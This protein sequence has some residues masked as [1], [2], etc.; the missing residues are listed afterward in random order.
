MPI[1]THTNLPAGR[2]I[3]V[4]VVDDSVV[5]RR[6]ITRALS[7]ENDLEV[8]GAASNGELALAKIPQLNPDV[9]TLDI[10][11]PKM[12]G[13]EAL[14]R[15]RQE[16]PTLTVIMFSALTE[17]GAA[18]TLEA[19]TLGASDYVTKSGSGGSVDDSLEHLKRE[20]APKI[21][22]FFRFAAPTSPLPPPKA[23]TP[24][25]R[26]RGPIGPA[27][28]KEII[29]V[30]V[31]TGGPNALAEVLP[32]FPKA[33]ACPVVIVQHMPP[34]FT[35]LLAERLD[36]QC[37]ISVTEA[38]DGVRLEPGKALVAPGGSH[39]VLRQQNGFVTA[40]LEDS[41][42]VNSCRPAVDRLFE[43]ATGIYGGKALAV[44]LTGMGQDGFNGAKQLKTKGAVVIVQDKASSVV[45]GMPGFIAQAG[46]ADVVAPI[47]EVAS[48]IL[49]R[50]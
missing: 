17:R 4:L 39:L 42:P 24:F 18:R 12:N 8:V 5:M 49:K 15:I 31:S 11:M 2:R 10:E 32:L 43:T 1:R 20:L 19:L 45:W 27:R 3:R 35:R 46:L 38:E 23:V 28:R 13:L 50:V 29:L 21:R 14:R 48:E 47:D 36:N 16:F 33:L 6:L 41:P 9:V 37:A 25:P 44:V 22:Q 30:G 7:G 26:P 34:I 40:N